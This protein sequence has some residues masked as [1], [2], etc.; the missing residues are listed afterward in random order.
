MPE[1]SPQIDHGAS[2]EYS[3]PF[4]TITPT[5]VEFTRVVPL[6]EMK[7][8]YVFAVVRACGGDRTKAAKLLGI[9]R[10]TVGVQLVTA[11]K[12]GLGEI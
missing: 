1:H 8:R 12:L 9:A 2:E 6:V 7:A 5:A 10:N 4:A 11:R 3:P